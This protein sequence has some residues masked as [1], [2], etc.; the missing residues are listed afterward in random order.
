M[1]VEL[2]PALRWIARIGGVASTLML[3]AFAFGGN[4]H[5]R[6]NATEAVAF[7]FFPLG[8]IAGFGLAWR[9]ELLGGLL[10]IGSLA[11]F[12]LWIF[13]SSGRIPTG[14]YFLLFATPGLFHLLALFAHWRRTA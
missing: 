7:L 8:I 5:L 1:P 6:L 14:P 4:E 10:T 11:M 9:R 12:Y 3:L 13:V 2:E